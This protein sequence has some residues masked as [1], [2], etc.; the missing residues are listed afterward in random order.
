[1]PTAPP[2]PAA[3]ESIS[4][5][6][7]HVTFTIDSD[8]E[9]G[10]NETKEP[11]VTSSLPTSPT[12]AAPPASVEQPL[13]SEE[14]ND[15]SASFSP[16]SGVPK[17]PTRTLDRGDENLVREA[18]LLPPFAS[19]E[20]EESG[21]GDHQGKSLHTEPEMTKISRETAPQG[22]HQ[23]SNLHFSISEQPDLSSAAVD[24]GG[25]DNQGFDLDNLDNLENVDI[26][27]SNPSVDLD[28]LP[29]PE[30]SKNGQ[31]AGEDSSKQD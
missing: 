2:P 14:Q 15:I 16:E 1:M 5:A 8:G 22:P 13:P 9:D 31:W 30:V 29:L 6:S 25:W 10:H 7:K 23:S 27:E 3:V 21:K 20:A 4:E 28:L 18:P 19:D 12:H 11:T 17:S 24:Q 26:D